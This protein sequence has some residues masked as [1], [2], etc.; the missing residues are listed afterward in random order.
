MA[1]VKQAE[2]KKAANE[3]PRGCG[4]RNRGSRGEASGQARSATARQRNSAG[5]V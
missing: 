2:P 4:F 5:D 1:P 3:E